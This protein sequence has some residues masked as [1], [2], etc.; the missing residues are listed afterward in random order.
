MRYIF[1]YRRRIHHLFL[2][3]YKHIYDC[4]WPAK[5]NNRKEIYLKDIPLKSISLFCIFISNHHFF[6]K[7][8][9]SEIIKDYVFSSHF[10][11][12]TRALFFSTR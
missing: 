11:I 3:K 9:S 2:Q 6:K 4:V 10:H 5:I 7:T 12:L 8:L 1:N